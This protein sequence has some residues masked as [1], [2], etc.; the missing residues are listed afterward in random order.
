MLTPEEPL[1]FLAFRL[2]FL[3][4]VNIFAIDSSA[5]SIDGTL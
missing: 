2:S 1:L 4:F 3:D 5:M